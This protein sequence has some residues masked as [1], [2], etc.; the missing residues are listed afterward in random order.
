MDIRQYCRLPSFCTSSS[1]LSPKLG[2]FKL[3]V[4]R[5]R[6]GNLKE[7]KIRLQSLACQS[8]GF[9]EV[10]ERMLNKAHLV[11]VMP[12]AATSS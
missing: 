8:S 6:H 9:K 3:S 12:A 2:L 7:M 5:L 4:M 1:V 11:T 10:A